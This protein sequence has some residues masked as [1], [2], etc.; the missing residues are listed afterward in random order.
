VPQTVRFGGTNDF[1]LASGL[2]GVDFF[3]S[4]PPHFGRAININ[5]VSR[6]HKRR[7]SRVWGRF[8]VNFK[9]KGFSDETSGT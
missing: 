5:R 2:T 3:F 7:V 1:H 9:V 4:S 8:G 6:E